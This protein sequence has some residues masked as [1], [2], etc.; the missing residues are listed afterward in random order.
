MRHLKEGESPDN[1]GK[2]IL[3]TERVL[4]EFISDKVGLEEGAH[5]GVTRPRVVQD[6]EVDLEG[7]H[8]DE[9]G[10]DD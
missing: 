3:H 4:V 6:H 7:S 1:L 10:N 2:A 8:E 5:L 9:N